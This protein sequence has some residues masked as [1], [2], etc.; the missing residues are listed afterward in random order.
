M[1]ARYPGDKIIGVT[2]FATVM[3]CTAAPAPLAIR[4]YNP[5]TN[6]TLHCTARDQTGKYSTILAATV[7]ACATQLEA[8]G[9][10]RE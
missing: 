5:E 7:E 1:A 10:V 2:L 4:M 9:F 8:R 6:Q 3:G